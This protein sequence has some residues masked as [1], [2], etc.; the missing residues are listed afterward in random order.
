MTWV[1]GGGELLIGLKRPLHDYGM[2]GGGGELLIVDPTRRDNSRGNRFLS[3]VKGYPGVW[4][5]ACLL[6]A[7]RLRERGR[8]Y[9]SMFLHIP[10]SIGLKGLKGLPFTD[11]RR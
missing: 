6:Q 11:Y 8:G 5:E 1:G 7:A 9:R 3:R 4:S 10:V 2:G